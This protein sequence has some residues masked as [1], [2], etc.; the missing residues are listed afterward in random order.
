MPLTCDIMKYNTIVFD[1]DGTLLNTLP[2]M[3]ASVNHTLSHFG[4]PERTMDEIRSFVG[5]GIPK[6]IERSVPAGTDEKTVSECLAFFKVYY[7]EHSLDETRPYEGIIPLLDKIAEAGIKTAVVTNKMQIAA[8]KVVKHFFGSRINVIIGQTP[9][10]PDKPAPQGVWLALEKL[11]SA[12][13]DA[14][15]IGDSEVDCMTAHNAELPAIGVTWGFRSRKVLEE[16]NAEYI[17]DTPESILS[18][19]K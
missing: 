18:V 6:L 11:G 17:I 12:K 4:F 14:V 15:Y 10:L 5:N 3:K 9:G 1:L 8:E 7:T 13:S 19:L 16:N 2:D